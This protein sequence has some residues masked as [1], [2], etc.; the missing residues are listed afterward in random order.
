MYAKAIGARR[1]SPNGWQ[2]GTNKTMDIAVALA[3]GDLRGLRLGP[4][5]ADRL[6]NLALHGVNLTAEETIAAEAWAGLNGLVW[7]PPMR[8]KSGPHKGAALDKARRN[9][10]RAAR[11][12][13]A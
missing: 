12:K 7:P 13:A 4:M 2:L 9:R 3:D 11:R 8:P 1:F 6:Y 10:R 5:R